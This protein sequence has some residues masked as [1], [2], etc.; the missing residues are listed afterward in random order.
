M[1]SLL[2]CGKKVP[3]LFPDQKGV[4]EILPKFGNCHVAKSIRAWSEFNGFAR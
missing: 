3:V 2:A 4:G 1:S